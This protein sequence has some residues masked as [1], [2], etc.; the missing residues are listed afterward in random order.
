MID[1]DA[2][3]D[4]QKAY[5]DSK[6]ANMLLARAL[7]RQLEAADFA[8]PVIAWSPGLVI[9]RARGGFFRH[10]RGH[11]PV[12]QAIFAVLARDLLRVTST[13]DRAGELLATLATDPDHGTPGFHYWSQQVQGPGRL[14]FG[15]AEPSVEAAD[16]A[17]ASR[18][19]SLGA[20][21]IGPSAD[22]PLS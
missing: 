21:L 16:E 6:L 14:R 19:W 17:L 7:A 12:G 10:S 20:R 11:N 2:P 15:P 4:A 18:L 5:K 8:M 9:P 13:P 3:F 1:S 22:R